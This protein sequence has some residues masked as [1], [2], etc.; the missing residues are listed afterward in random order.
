MKKI[1]VTFL[2]LA[3]ILWGG[4]NFFGAMALGHILEN[5]IGAPV[6]VGRIHVGLFS[7]SVGL[8]NIQ[9]KNPKGFHEETLADIHELSIKYDLPAFFRGRV[10][11][12]EVR[13]DF[14]D[15]TIEKN[16]SQVNLMELGAVKGMTRG[17]GSG[18]K[19]EKPG[20]PG[21]TTKAPDVQMDE[22]YL[23]IG[24]TRY[25]DSAVQPPVVKEYDIGVHQEIFKY[26]TSTQG[27]VKD[28]AFIILRKVGLSSLTSNFDLLLKGGGGEVQSAF[29]KFFK[30]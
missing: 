4:L 5:A 22:V 14:G 29:Q 24:K 3:V 23:N 25:V 30:H 7:S 28:I 27:L 17:V 2:A 19:E 10:H 20:K 15:V 9:I 11:F 18:R 1:L 21:Q 8:Y 13:L 16:S 6:S 12:K 26:V